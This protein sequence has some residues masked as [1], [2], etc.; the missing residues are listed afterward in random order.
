MLSYNFIYQK[1]ITLA[2]Q[3]KRVKKGANFHQVKYFFTVQGSHQINLNLSHD[4]SQFIDD[5]LSVRR[6]RVSALV[7]FSEP[8]VFVMWLFLRQVVL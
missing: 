8:E 5:I 1:N 3:K 4:S 7:H 6:R 2:N